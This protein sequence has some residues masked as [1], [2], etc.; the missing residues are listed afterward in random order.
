MSPIF[1]GAGPE[2]G[3]KS[4]GEAVLRRR[5]AGLTCSAT[6][7][8]ATILSQVTQGFDVVDPTPDD[9]H[10]RHCEFTSDV[11]ANDGRRPRAPLFASHRDFFLALLDTPRVTY[12]EL[13]RLKLAVGRSKAF[14]CRTC[15]RWINH[16]TESPQPSQYV[17]HVIVAAALF[18]RPL[19]YFAL[20]AHYS[21]IPRG[22]RS[23][24]GRGSC[25]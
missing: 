2:I 4:A 7:C 8:S 24:H 16:Y 15:H 6:H 17:V 19:P 5:P 3:G 18:F 20:V 21:H 14:L 22:Y 13:R 1:L 12:D 11:N 25:V 9:H 10:A 23:R